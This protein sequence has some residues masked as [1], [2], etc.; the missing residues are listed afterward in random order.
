MRLPVVDQLL[1]AS[2]RGPGTASASAGTFALRFL[3]L[4]FTFGGGD[5]LAALLSRR[6]SSARRCSSSFLLLQPAR[7]PRFGLLQASLFSARRSSAAL[8]ARFF[9]SSRRL[10]SSFL[11]LADF[12]AT[13]SRPRRA[14]RR[15]TFGGG[16]GGEASDLGD[17]QGGVCT[18]FGG[19]GRFS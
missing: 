9:F 3:L 19:G 7:F 17:R 15:S 13:R 14:W 10:A 18:I 16:G 4:A 1:P 6:S 8:S 5:A 11:L 12:S 2:A